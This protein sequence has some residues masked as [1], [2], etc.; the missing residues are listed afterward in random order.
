V[1]NLALYLKVGC[2]LNGR[3]LLWFSERNYCW[4]LGLKMMSFAC[5]QIE[6]QWMR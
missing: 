6:L 2:H 5:L 1:A 3:R 4:V